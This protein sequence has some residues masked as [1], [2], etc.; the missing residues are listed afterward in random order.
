MKGIDH[1]CTQESLASVGF[2]IETPLFALSM[3]MLALNCVVLQGQE[4]N[5]L[6]SLMIS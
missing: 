1:K 2:R 3:V 6:F 4:L 5:L